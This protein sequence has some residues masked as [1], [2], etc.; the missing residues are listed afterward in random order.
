MACGLPVVASNVGG[1]KDLVHDGVTGTLVATDDIQALGAA[2]LDY[3][4]SQTKCQAHGLAG[5]LL[6]KQSFTLKRMIA[7][8][9]AVFDEM[10]SRRQSRAK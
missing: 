4:A 5:A 10:I 7:K 6:V 8:Y 3:V 2:M 9:L 1:M